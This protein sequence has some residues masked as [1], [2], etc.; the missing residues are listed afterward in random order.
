[1]WTVFVYLA[2]TSQLVSTANQTA[3]QPQGTFSQPQSSELTSSL[4]SPTLINPPA[5]QLS[6][7][8]HHYQPL[9]AEEPLL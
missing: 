4:V 3:S 7:G 5:G 1:M 8:F 6:P 2:T 9:R